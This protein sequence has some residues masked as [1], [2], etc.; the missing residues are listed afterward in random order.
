MVGVERGECGKALG[1][2]V[3]DQLGAVVNRAIII[4]IAGEEAV[5]RPHPAGSNDEV[6]G[7]EVK[8]L[9]HACARRQ[10]QCVGAS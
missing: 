5:I 3:A 1:G 10:L 2:A 8:E 6:V 4:E 9:R 7:V